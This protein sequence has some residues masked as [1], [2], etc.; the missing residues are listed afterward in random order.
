VRARSRGPVRA[1][2]AKIANELVR[3]RAWEP[4]CYAR[5][6]D[7][8]DERVGLSARTI[9]DL[10]RVD[11]LFFR[12][13]QLRAALI[14]GRLGWTKVRLVARAATR[15]DESEW[16]AY[17]RRVNTRTLER[18]VRKVDRGSVE[19]GAADSTA[20]A[21]SRRFEVACT[22]EV[23]A[24][25]LYTTTVARRVHGGRLHIS[26]AAEAIAAEV[27]SAVPI[28]PAGAED[29]C[30]VT[31]SGRE[32]SRAAALERL[33]EDAAGQ[34]P[35]FSSAPTERPAEIH[36][37][38]LPSEL[39]ALLQD[40]EES[41]PFELD[42]RLRAV[43]AMEQRLDAELGP[44]LERFVS[45]RLFVAFGYASQDAYV[46]DRLGVDPS[47]LRALLRIERACRINGVLEAGYREA[48]VTSLQA[49]TLAPLLVAD[50]LERWSTA[51]V[52]R[53]GRITLRRL[54]D[55]VDRAVLIL[56]T[57][58]VTWVRTGGL[59]AKARAE[60][61]AGS[62][63][64]REMRARASDLEGN[65]AA[66][67]SLPETSTVAFIGPA[68]IVQL[69]RGVL[70]TV[71]RRMERVT[72]RMPTPGEALDVMLEHALESWGERDGKLRRAH[73]IFE[74]DGWRCLVPGCTS[75]RNLQ[76]HHIR[77]RSAGGTDDCENVV[78]L[79]A[80]HHLRGVHAG[81]IRISGRAPDRLRFAIGLRPD[82][83]PLAVYRSG[84]ELVG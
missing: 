76:A 39:Q 2:L 42:R 36:D 67:E 46:R 32:G 48:R 34:E 5:L 4:L 58:P 20:D 44:L 83:P 45:R 80:F 57:D 81:R 49:R 41:D 65:G 16:I 43:V 79:C 17:A 40:L 59:P 37:A 15:K 21:R 23:R 3:R 7:Y 66:V 50:G 14:R 8:A 22:R 18:E 61:D 47:K 63:D 9:Q 10:A 60:E 27:L 64:D 31:D 38:T 55:D 84:D 35:A 75:M 72:G 53:A 71:R 29:L 74:R 24:R 28:D 25:W 52:A 13:P 51:W 70:C 56:E 82:G 12:L 6:S 62:S 77:F 26:G 1:A 11:G 33:S 78:T 73:S 54:R 30:D 69:F 19:A 68:E